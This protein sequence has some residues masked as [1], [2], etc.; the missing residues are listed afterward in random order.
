MPGITRS[1]ALIQLLPYRVYVRTVFT[2]VLDAIRQHFKA[3]QDPL[4]IAVCH[5]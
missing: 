2:D 1:Y 4:R 5:V 3:G